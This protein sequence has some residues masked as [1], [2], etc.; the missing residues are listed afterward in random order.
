MATRA[1][2]NINQ[3]QR[4]LILE[5]ACITCHLKIITKAS[6]SHIADMTVLMEEVINAWCQM[7]SLE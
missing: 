1:I 5:H 6:Y 4:D 2:F 3:T 7:V